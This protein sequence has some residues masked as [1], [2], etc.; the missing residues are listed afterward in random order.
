MD[1]ESFNT[2]QSLATLVRT[3]ATSKSVLLQPPLSYSAVKRLIVVGDDE[4]IEVNEDAGDELA[5]QLVEAAQELSFEERVGG[6]EVS[7]DPA[8]S[9]SAL[10]DADSREAR[11]LKPRLFLAWDIADEP[12]IVGMLTACEWA[13]DETL[14]T[15]RFTHQYLSDHSVPRFTSSN[16]LFVDVVSSTGEPHGV[17]ALLLLNAYLLVCRSSKFS[18]LV[19]IAVTTR[20]NGVGDSAAGEVMTAAAVRRSERH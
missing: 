18:Y 2:K 1:H 6:S 5:Q 14:G 9:L 7:V 12:S 8:A 13:R 3:V 16:T 15:E 17:G 11:A 19:T 20:P 4:E 10:F